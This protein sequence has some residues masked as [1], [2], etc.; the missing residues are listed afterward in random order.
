MKVRLIIS[1][2]LLLFSAAVAAEGG[3]Y[4]EKMHQE[5]NARLSSSSSTYASN[6]DKMLIEHNRGRADDLESVI[7]ANPPSA[8]HDMP[9]KPANQNEANRPI[10]A[11]DF[12]QGAFGSD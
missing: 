2:S 3:N 9:G 11:S 8:G 5:R 7:S 6:L 4:W 12:K 10:R 1:A